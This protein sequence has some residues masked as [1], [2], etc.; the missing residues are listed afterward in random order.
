M[1]KAY[2]V[3]LNLGQFEFTKATAMTFETYSRER[4]DAHCLTLKPGPV[5]SMQRLYGFI[6]CQ[7]QAF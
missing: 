7:P 3:Q 5:K 2:E 6:G 1:A 4:L